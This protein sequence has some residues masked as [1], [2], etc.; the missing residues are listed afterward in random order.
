MN[1]A[2]GEEA[3]GLIH[4]ESGEAMVFETGVSKESVAAITREVTL[5]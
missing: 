4:E 3:K 2:G 1:Q 5:Q